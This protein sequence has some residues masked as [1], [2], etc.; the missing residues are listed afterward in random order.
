[1]LV[2]SVIG[3]YVANGSALDLWLMLG[4][5]LLGYALRQFRFDVAPLLLA[6]VLDERAETSFR[7]ALTI[8]VGD[9]ATFVQGPAAR[10]L[11]A[12][13]TLLLALQLA[14]RA[15]GWRRQS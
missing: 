7:R 6:P 5:G 1:V 3:V 13:A 4:F 8:S 15:L 9:Y 10:A 14:A 11:L 2:I 12:I